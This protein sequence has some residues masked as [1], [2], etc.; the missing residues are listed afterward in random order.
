MLILWKDVDRLKREHAK[1]AGAPKNKWNEKHCSMSKHKPS[2][3]D[4][5]T[6]AIPASKPK[7]RELQLRMGFLVPKNLP[8]QLKRLKTMK[9]WKNLKE[10][11]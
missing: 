9:T 4:R 7:L 5:E 6:L 2:F 8:Q 1:C 11:S 3:A 10:D